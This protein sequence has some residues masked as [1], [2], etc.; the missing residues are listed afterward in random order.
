MK[1][2]SPHRHRRYAA[3]CR[4]RRKQGLSLNSATVAVLGDCRRIRRQI[5][6]VFDD[7]SHRIIVAVVAKNGDYSRQFGQGLSE[8]N[9]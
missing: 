4:K 6:A 8:Q 7:Y 5:V 2:A 9:I 1:L 3:D